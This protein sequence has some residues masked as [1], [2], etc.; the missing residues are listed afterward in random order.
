MNWA[1]VAGLTCYVVSVVVWMLVLSRVDVS[2]AYPFL[3]IG[4]ILTTVLG[5]MFFNEV[6]TAERIGGIVLIC[7]GVVLVARS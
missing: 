6:I 2:Y 4:Y 3:S 1:I 5:Y 7:L